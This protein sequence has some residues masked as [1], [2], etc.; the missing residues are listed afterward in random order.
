MSLHNIEWD[1]LEVAAR[2]AAVAGGFAAMGYYRGALADA[3]VLGEEKSPTTEADIQATLAILRSLDPAIR[4]IAG[5]NKFGHCYFAEELERKDDKIEQEQE[6]SKILNELGGISIYVSRT[7]KEFVESFEHCIAILFDGLDGT[8]NFTAGIPLFCTA[9][10]FFIEKEPR[11]AAIYDAHHNVVYYGSLRGEDLLVKP[12]GRA[13]MWHVQSGSNTNLLTMKKNDRELIGTH[14]T[15][16]DREKMKEMVDD[17]E[18]LSSNFAATYMLN[19]GQL[20]LAYVASSNL[21]AFVNNYT[22]IWDVA[23]GEVLVRAIGG[24]VTDFSGN[25]IKYESNSKVEIVAASST[26]VHSKLL[27]AIQH[28]REGKIKKVKGK[29]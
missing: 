8:V 14:L 18:Q 24:K 20:A 9:I 15:R 23:A 29:R 2:N 7:A 19:S 11:V 16:S 1:K 28:N 10:A 3:F 6:V 27:Q 21:S 4:V 22:N 12:D 25:P 17:L 26:E 5:T 13:F